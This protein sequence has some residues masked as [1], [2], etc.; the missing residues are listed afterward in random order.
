MSPTGALDGCG[1]EPPT[2]IIPGEEESEG[3]IF[4]IVVGSIQ[5]ELCV[6]V[7]RVQDLLDQ[8]MLHCADC[9]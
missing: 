1:V 6:P 2:C 5:F 4:C 7:D 8:G 3:V 9:L